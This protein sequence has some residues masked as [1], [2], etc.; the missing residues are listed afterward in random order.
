VTRLR[1]TIAV[2]L[3]LL[4]APSV[5]WLA[6]TTVLGGRLPLGW[7]TELFF[8]ACC[9]ASAAAAWFAH[10][11]WP[12]FLL[13]IGALYTWLVTL[14]ALSSLLFVRARWGVDAILEEATE[15][16]FGGVAFLWNTVLLP[17]LF[18]VLFILAAALCLQLRPW[19][20]EVPGIHV[21]MRLHARPGQEAA[22]EDVIAESFGPARANPK[23]LYVQALRAIDDPQLFTIQSRWTDEAAF[24][25]Y[26]GVANT[27]RFLERV[28]AL[29]DQ[30]PEIVRHRSIA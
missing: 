20:K 1:R 28:Q 9:I 14:P 5:L 29:V 15:R 7:E 18:P 25:D 16:G 11:W 23:C 17:A 10:R 30:P 21:F 24:Q 19:R 4:A 6:T 22:L 13:G 2:I 3:A 8:V 26:V 12:A 27:L